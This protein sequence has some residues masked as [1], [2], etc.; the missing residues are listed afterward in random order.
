[1]LGLG[2]TA[3]FGRANAQATDHVLVEIAN[4]QSRH[5]MPRAIKRTNDSIPVNRAV[6]KPAA[7]W[8]PTS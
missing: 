7:Q 8:M 3:V 2:G 4:G 1:M 6:A 5:Q